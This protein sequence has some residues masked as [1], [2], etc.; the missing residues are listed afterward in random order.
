MNVL[1]TGANGFI[2]T[3]VTERLAHDGRFLVRPAVRRTL[4]LQS[5]AGAP[6]V[7][8]DLTDQTDWRTALENQDAVVHLAARVHVMR[9]A[10]A[11]PLAEFRRTN[12]DGSRALALQ[13]AAAGVRRFV[14][15]SSLKV[16]GEEGRFTEADPLAPVD[17][18]GISKAE[19]ERALKE[20]ATR[21]GMEL[22]I[23]RPPLVYGP[24]VKANFA[25]LM[26]AIA[27]GLPLP[28][29][30]IRNR[31]SLVAVDNLVDLLAVCLVHPAAAGETFLVSDGEDLSTPDLARRLGCA[32]S[33]PARIVPLPPSWLAGA[34]TLAGRRSAAHRLLSSLTVDITKVREHLGW[35]APVRV[36][37]ALRRAVA[38]RS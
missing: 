14:F 34:A 29:G 3:A 35:T 30:S 25:A 27:R 13:A 31:R 8:G 1:V 33:R 12:V 19:G 38:A 17:P 18:Y 5:V 37:E 15:V 9:D 11:D 36:D 23:V 2:G 22:V 16:H 7:V 32:M 20:V 26:R 10:A 4:A 24:G 21:S 6:V 28:I